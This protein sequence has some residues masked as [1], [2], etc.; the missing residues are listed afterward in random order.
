MIAPHVSHPGGSPQPYLLNHK[1]QRLTAKKEGLEHTFSIPP[2]NGR[3][4][5]KRC[6]LHGVA[7]VKPYVQRWQQR[8]HSANSGAILRCPAAPNSLHSAAQ[9]LMVQCR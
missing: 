1:R 5:E 8:R 6:F 3:M 9:C 7:A 2:R 4:A